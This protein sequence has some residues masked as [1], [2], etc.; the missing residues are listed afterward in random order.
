MNERSESVPFPKTRWSLVL[1]TRHDAEAAASAQDALSELC[2]AYWYP[3]YAFARRTGLPPDDAADACQ[4]F[5]ARILSANLFAKADPQR[6]R[7]RSF[8]LGTFQNHLSELTRAAHREKRG[9]KQVI[10]SLDRSL[11]E[12]WLSDEPADVASP[13][14]LFER[15]W[16]N[17]LLR[18]S[19]A[20]LAEEY[21]RRGRGQMFSRL[22]EFLAWNSTDVKLADVARELGLSV[23][24]VRV[25]IHRMRAEFRRKLEEQVADTIEKPADIEAELKHLLRCVDADLDNPSTARNNPPPMSKKE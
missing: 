22:R 24:T 1:R 19:L 23:G 6:G 5:F 9:G 2:E 25:G 20:A 8:L 15:S 17:I 12:G 16:A 4:S 7:L 3:I 13:D 10:V 14:I 11:A 18:R 21:E